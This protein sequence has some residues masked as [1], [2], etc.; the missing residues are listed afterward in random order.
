M[1]QPALFPPPGI[2]SNLIGPYTL[3]PYNRITTAICIVAT[4]VVVALR[5]YIKQWIVKRL[6]WEDGKKDLTGAIRGR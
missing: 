1:D 5:L 4:G 3:N 2:I 6:D